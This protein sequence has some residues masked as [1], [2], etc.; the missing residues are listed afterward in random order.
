MKNAIYPCRVAS[1]WLARGSKF[2]GELAQ[3]PTFLYLPTPI[4]SQ[5]SLNQL[6]LILPE[7]V[8]GDDRNSV[9]IMNN[10]SPRES[11]PSS[12]S[13]TST[14]TG[15]SSFSAASSSTPTPRESPKVP[16]GLGLEVRQTS[17][18]ARPTLGEWTFQ[19]WH[20]FVLLRSPS[21][22]PSYTYT[23]PDACAAPYYF[24]KWAKGTEVDN[25]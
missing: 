2:D 17:K 23:Y 20:S 12:S 16:P 8:V 10:K 9:A 25:M 4:T 11:P 18:T 15:A 6:L 14:A 1:A 19:G 21:P 3:S 22:S 24:W 7:T 13:A 5:F